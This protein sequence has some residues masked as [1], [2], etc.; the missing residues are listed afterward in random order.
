[1]AKKIVQVI[2]TL[3]FPDVGDEPGRIN[4]TRSA[5]SIQ[6]I[7]N[8]LRTHMVVPCMNSDRIYIVEIDKVEMKIVKTIGS[9][10][11]R[12]YDMS[13]PYAVHVLPLKGAPVHIATMG[14]NYGHGKGDFL[15]ID[16]HS[17]EIRERHNRGGFYGFGG[18]FSFQTRRNLLIAC[19]WGHPRLFRGGFTR[20]DIENGGFRN[21]AG[22]MKGYSLLSF[23]MG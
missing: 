5:A 20:S 19:E 16:R 1:F 2:S 4:W 11:L 9:E 14:D 10:L 23:C 8:V 12:H 13:C 17:F 3:N 22:W 6:A 21:P 15:L 18:D 7:P